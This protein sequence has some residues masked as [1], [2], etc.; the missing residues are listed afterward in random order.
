MIQA[1]YHAL[2]VFV[3]IMKRLYPWES[4]PEIEAIDPPGATLDDVNVIHVSRH[5]G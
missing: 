3:H 2:Q 4:F 5:T 1:F